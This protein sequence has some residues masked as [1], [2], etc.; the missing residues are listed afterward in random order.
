LEHQF[1]SE[2]FSNENE[3]WHECSCEAKTDVTPHIYG[4]DN[5]CDFCGY[6]TTDSRFEQSIGDKSPEGGNGGGC[7]SANGGNTAVL[8][9]FTSCGVAVFVVNKKRKKH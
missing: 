6:K 4:K 1:S 3:H 9:A 7:G 2:W 5:I 8:S